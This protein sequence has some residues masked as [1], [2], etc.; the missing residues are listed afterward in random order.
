MRVCLRNP[1]SVLPSSV[2][3]LYPPDVRNA[4][5]ARAYQRASTEE[6][7][8]RKC[9]TNFLEPLSRHDRV[10]VQELV[11]QT[12]ASGFHVAEGPALQ[13]EGGAGYDAIRPCSNGVI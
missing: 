11:E 8:I 2:L 1:P 13:D 9:G 7:V 4:S 6:R 10:T 5:A 3:K 12:T